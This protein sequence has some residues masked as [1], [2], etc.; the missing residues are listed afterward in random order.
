MLFEGRALAM[1][2]PDR[3]L[4]NIITTAALAAVLVTSLAPA[5]AAAEQAADSSGVVRVLD[6][7]A[8]VLSDARNR[9]RFAGTLE[10]MA[11]R[12]DALSADLVAGDTTV[13][14]VQFAS[15]ARDV[16]G[17]TDLQLLNDPEAVATF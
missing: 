10:R 14:L 11:D 5:T 4:R 9:A 17:C 12:V 16:E 2:R 6:F 13:S 7:S 15:K 1:V 8:S 3:A